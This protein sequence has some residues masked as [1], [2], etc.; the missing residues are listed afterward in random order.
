[1]SVSSFNA[2]KRESRRWN[3]TCA[4]CGGVLLI[5]VALACALGWIHL[6]ALDVLLLLALF[7]I[8]PLALSFA[9]VPPDG[10]PPPG[11]AGLLIMAQPFAALAGG[12]SF[13]LPTG[14][15]AGAAAALWLVFT[16]LLALAALATLTRLFRVRN[17]RLADA[18]LGAALLYLPI[19][20]AW[21]ALARLGSR[22]LGFSPTIVLLTA[23]HFH[24]ITLA[25][26]ILTGLTGRAIAGRNWWT[27]TMYRAA[28]GGMLVEPLL[29]AAGIT[30]TQVSGVRIPEAAAAT[31]LALSVIVIAAIS[32][33]WVVP[34]THP[35]LA[36]GLL[37]ASSGSVVLTMALACAY[38]I[39]E[40]T[41]A[42]TITIAQMIAAHGWVNALGFG[43]CG[44]LGWRLRLDRE[45][46]A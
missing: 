24:F 46:Q 2:R 23:A 6:D 44:L 31:L 32:L 11:G 8:T 10:L 30:L 4:I 42:W 25:A 33:H 18:C 26:L 9:L 38:A 15:L 43:L 17:V 14:P 3:R 34:A 35:R 28:A 29:V 13:L 40:T 27:R 12:V 37:A 39:G 45:G 5:A 22:P 41:G 1:M 21:L 16:I 7:V 19:G 36:Q 20:G